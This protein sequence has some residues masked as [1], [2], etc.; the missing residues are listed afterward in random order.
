MTKIS[1]PKFE[2]KKSIVLLMGSHFHFIK[3]LYLMPHGYQGDFGG[4]IKFK[5]TAN[6]LAVKIPQVKASKEINKIHT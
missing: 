6:D 5:V 2:N 4:N 3:F 1:I